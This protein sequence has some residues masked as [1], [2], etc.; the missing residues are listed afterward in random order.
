MKAYKLTLLINDHDEVGDEI[1]D[2]IENQKYPN[3]CIAPYVMDMQSVDVGEWSDEHPLNKRSTMKEKFNKLFNAP[4]RPVKGK[5]YTFD[6]NNSGGSF[7][8]NERSGI[9]HYVIIEAH[10]LKHAMS[11]AEDIGIYFH[12][13]ASGQDCECCGNRWYEPWDDKG[14][15]EPQ[16]YD[17]HPSKKEPSVFFKKGQ[18]EI[19]IHYLDGRIEW[20]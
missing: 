7:E 8:Y 15:E 11:R 3:Y 13:V 9:T 16:V 18:K 19:A 6:Q 14:T 1:K 20:F 10:D 2:I 17:E 4:D 12:G 5:F